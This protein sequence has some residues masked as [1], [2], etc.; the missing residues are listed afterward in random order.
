VGCAGSL[1][2]DKTGGEGASGAQGSHH[3]HQRRQ[4]VWVT[5]F[6]HGVEE[7]AEG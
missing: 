4:G 1:R 6:S 7:R 5:V 2:E 3:S